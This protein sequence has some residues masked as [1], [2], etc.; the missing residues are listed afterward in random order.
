MGRPL[1][2]GDALVAGTAKARDLSVATRNVSDFR[3]LDLVVT[4]PWD[5]A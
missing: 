4:N 5:F 3:G 1:D 2:L